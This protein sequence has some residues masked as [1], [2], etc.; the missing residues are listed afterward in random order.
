[1]SVASYSA[2]QNVSLTRSGNTLSVHNA[3]VTWKDFMDFHSYPVKR[4]AAL[5]P[6][7]DSTDLREL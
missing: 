1:M 7:E 4:A 2:P 3:S 5:S 6:E